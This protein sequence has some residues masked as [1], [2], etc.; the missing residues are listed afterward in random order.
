MVKNPLKYEADKL[1]ESVI[2]E[3]DGLVAQETNDN[4]EHVSIEKNKWKIER[5]ISTVFNS[6]NQ[7]FLKKMF[8]KNLE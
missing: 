8:E 4:K 3:Y 2:Q 1:N 5:S 7:T 6:V